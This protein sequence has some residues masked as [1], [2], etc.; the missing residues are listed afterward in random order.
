MCHERL[1]CVTV[2]FMFWQ[3][4]HLFLMLLDDFLNIYS[5]QCE[6]CQ[7]K[8]NAVVVYK[9]GKHK[10]TQNFNTK[11]FRQ[12]LLHEANCGVKECKHLLATVSLTLVGY[13][14]DLSEVMSSI[15][16]KPFVKVKNSLLNRFTQFILE[17]NGHSA[18]VCNF[19]IQMKEVV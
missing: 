6:W 17:Y 11:K 5:V 1:S 14:H 18:P 9:F 2:I 4:L 12:V 13:R 8:I 7:V 16:K 19:A 15:S 10:P 3:E